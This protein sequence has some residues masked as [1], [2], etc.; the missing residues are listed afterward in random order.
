LSF[1]VELRQFLHVARAFNLSREEVDARI[2]HPWVTGDSIPLQDRSWSAQKSKLTIVEGPD[3]QAGDLGLGRGWG[4]ALRE[5]RDVT[6]ELVA[7]AQRQVGPSPA[8]ELKH[9]IVSAAQLSPLPLRAV[10]ELVAVRNP[11]RRP[12][13]LV[14]VTEQAVWELLHRGSLAMFRGDRPVDRDHWQQVLLSWPSWIDAGP[15]EVT[16]AAAQPGDAPRTT[17]G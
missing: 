2:L 10:V 4:N 6:A 11:Q 14:A 12:S 9:D 1:H 7:E 3:L 8:D 13:E 16:V 15:G 5:G 17:T